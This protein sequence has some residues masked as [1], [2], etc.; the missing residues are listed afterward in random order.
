MTANQLNK[1]NGTGENPVSPLNRRT[2]YPLGCSWPSLPDL[3]LLSTETAS[4]PT[5]SCA[6]HSQGSRQLNSCLIRTCTSV[7]HNTRVFPQ[8]FSALPSAVPSSLPMA[9]ICSCSISSTQGLNYRDSGS[10]G[11]RDSNGRNSYN[12]DGNKGSLC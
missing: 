2:I 7:L 10:S 6:P 5:S 12:G 1:P 4:Q 9:G 8:G 3:L 11:N